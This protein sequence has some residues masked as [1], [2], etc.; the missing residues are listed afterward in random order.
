MRNCTASRGFSI[1]LRQSLIGFGLGESPAFA[2]VIPIG[3][4]RML[5]TA[6]DE[7]F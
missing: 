1:L 2:T 6:I 5:V 7:I 3:N 4:K